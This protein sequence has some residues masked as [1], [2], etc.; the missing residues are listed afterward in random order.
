[1]NLHSDFFAGVFR[2]DDAGLG[3]SDADTSARNCRSLQAG[4]PLRFR[5]SIDSRGQRDQRCDGSV[6]LGLDHPRLDSV[7][8]GGGGFVRPRHKRCSPAGTHPIQAPPFL[9]RC[10]SVTFP[11][12][13]ATTPRASP[14][15]RQLGLLIRTL[16]LICNSIGKTIRG[17]IDPMM[18]GGYGENH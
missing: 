3:G 18:G 10:L 1:M 5:P 6:R 17:R 7:G 2:A 12:G 8:A 13:N 11:S 15:R 9:D 14:T 4:H 16:C